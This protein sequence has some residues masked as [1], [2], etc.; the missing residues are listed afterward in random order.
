MRKLIYQS[1][2]TLDG[3]V[4]GPNGE[5][6]WHIID[7]ATH[8]VF[9]QT[10]RQIGGYA[11]GRKTYDLMRG[12]DQLG[13]KPDDPAEIK[14]FHDDW[15]A[16]PKLVFSHGAYAPGPNATLA[17]GDAVEAVRALKAGDGKMIALNGTGLAASLA[18]SGLID[19]YLLY[20][21]PVVL[22]G[23][24]RL[25]HEGWLRMNLELTGT[26]AFPSGVVEMRY[27]PRN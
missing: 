24:T 20:V 5:L 12:W 11:M 19:E 18:G 7:P 8:E 17:Q 26:A 25:F 4:G 13:S 15:I 21:H 14:G 1:L 6:D 16:T 23:G 3:Y 9:N 27:R 10:Q 2:V 22:G